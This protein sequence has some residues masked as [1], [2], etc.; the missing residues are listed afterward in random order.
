MNDGLLYAIQKIHLYKSFTNRDII[1]KVDSAP[2][3]TRLKGI[4]DVRISIVS[5]HKQHKQRFQGEKNN[6][7]ATHGY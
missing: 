1:S 6:Q 5:P 4:N 3:I 2:M 7:N